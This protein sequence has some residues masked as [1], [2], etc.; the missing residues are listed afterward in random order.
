[1]RTPGAIAHAL[2][3]ALLLLLAAAPSFAQVDEAAARAAFIYNF[4]AFTDWPAPRMN[5]SAE[6]LLCVHSGI[7]PSLRARLRQLEGKPVHGLRTRVLT[8]AAA[9]NAARCHL[10]VLGADGLAADTALRAAVAGSG[11]LTVCD[12]DPAPGTV[13]IRLVRDGSRLVF[14]IDRAALDRSGLVVSSKLLRL[15]RTRP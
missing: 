4:A 5:E 2:S 15:A 10:L 3:L 14:T 1:V 9:G 11:T 8:T 12:C 7:N 6:F 13:G